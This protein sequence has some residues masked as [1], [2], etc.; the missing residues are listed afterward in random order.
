MLK[1][2]QKIIKQLVQAY[3]HESLLRILACSPQDFA[4]SVMVTEEDLYKSYKMMHQ[5]LDI[6]AQIKLTTGEKDY[7]EQVKA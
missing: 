7:F 4:E 3:L 6:G 2:Q 5:E 1:E